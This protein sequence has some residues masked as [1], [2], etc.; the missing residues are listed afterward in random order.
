M[1]EFVGADMP[2]LGLDRLM[3]EAKERG[4]DIERDSLGLP[5]ALRLAGTPR[6]QQYPQARAPL[7]TFAGRPTVTS[8]AVTPAATPSATSTAVTPIATPA[9]TPGNESRRQL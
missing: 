6:L 9:A 4:T 5:H 1:T 3:Q 7:T 8:T 2:P